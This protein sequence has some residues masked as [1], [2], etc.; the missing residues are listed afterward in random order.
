[1]IYALSYR[2][3][4]GLRNEISDAIAQAVQD[5]DEA[6][7]RH[8]PGII[9]VCDAQPSREYFCVYCAHGRVFLYGQGSPRRYFRHSPPSCIEDPHLNDT[10]VMTRGSAFC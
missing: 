1:M 5:D 6:A 2:L 8:C 9:Y 3:P 10:V 4:Q 7:L